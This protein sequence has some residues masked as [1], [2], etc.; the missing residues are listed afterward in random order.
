M[1]SLHF[2][3]IYSGFENK[4]A[5]KK[6]NFASHNLKELQV[7]NG[8]DL[9]PS[10]KIRGNSGSIDGTETYHQFLMETNKA[11]NRMHDPTSDSALRSVNFCLDYPM[12]HE[13]GPAGIALIGVGDN[14][15]PIPWLDAYDN[16]AA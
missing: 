10:E 8:V 2:C 5:R 11:W 6:L 1:N 4:P 14:D 16:P 15:Q 9:Y 7:R 3:F 12:Y 13:Q